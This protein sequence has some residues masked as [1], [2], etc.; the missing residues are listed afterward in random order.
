MDEPQKEGWFRSNLGLLQYK[1]NSVGN[2]SVF[3]LKKFLSFL[4]ELKK[5]Q[6]KSKLF[7]D[8]S[9]WLPKQFQINV[10]SFFTRRILVV[11]TLIF[12]WLIELCDCHYFSLNCSGSSTRSLVAGK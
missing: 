4:C 3:S 10:S 9:N 12:K 8:R 11:L 5:E 7:V 1:N 2:Q 6:F